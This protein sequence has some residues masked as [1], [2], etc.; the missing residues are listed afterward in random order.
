MVC[1]ILSHSG[2]KNPERRSFAML[3][4]TQDDG[5]FQDLWTHLQGFFFNNPILVFWVTIVYHYG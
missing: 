5:V 3:R 4:I 1:V 2:A